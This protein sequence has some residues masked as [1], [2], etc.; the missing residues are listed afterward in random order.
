MAKPDV[1]LQP[2]KGIITQAAANIYAAYVIAGQVSK[3]A[4]KKEVDT[5]INRSIR[6]AIHIARTVDASVHSDRE[7]PDDG[8]STLRESSIE[9]RM[10]AAKPK[11]AADSGKADSG[12]AEA[13]KAESGKAESG[14]AESGKAEAEVKPASQQP[15]EK[16]SPAAAK[17]DAAVDQAKSAGPTDDEI[18]DMLDTP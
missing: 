16:K 15:T 11:Q 8:E 10:P 7:L 12:K 17:A 6:E 9:T 14:K 13:G 2:S 3:S 4:D 5:W 18:A 1:T